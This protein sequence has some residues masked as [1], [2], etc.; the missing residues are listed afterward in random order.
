MYSDRRLKCDTCYHCELYFLNCIKDAIPAGSNIF[1][2]SA[3]R[4]GE[5]GKQTAISMVILIRPAVTFILVFL[6]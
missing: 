2:E 1:C 4:L 3:L 5:V 6:L